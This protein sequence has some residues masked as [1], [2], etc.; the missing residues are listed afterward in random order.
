MKIAGG[1]SSFLNNLPRP[2]SHPLFVTSA[3][4]E[5]ERER[6][7]FGACVDKNFT[8][9]RVA[10]EFMTFHVFAPYATPV[11]KFSPVLR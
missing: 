9:Q 5:R 10:K 4:R 7:R 8:G 6:E 1:V 2:P 11:K 3:E